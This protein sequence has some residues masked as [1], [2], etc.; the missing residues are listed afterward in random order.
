M[1]TVK[2]SPR[3]PKNNVKSNQTATIYCVIRF[4]NKKLVYPTGIKI[5]AKYWYSKGQRV[6]Q[7]KQFPQYPEIN[8]RLSKLESIVET[9]YTRF[10]NENENKSP[11]VEELR[12]SIRSVFDPDIKPETQKDFI[13]FFK[14]YL[15]NLTDVA[16]K[17]IKG[18][19]RT[20]ALL[21]GFK[22]KIPFDSI[23]YSFY[24]GFVNYMQKELKFSRNTIGKYIRIMKTVLY[25]AEEQHKK[26]YVSNKF[27]AFTEETT[28]IHLNAKELELIENLDLSDNPRLDKVRDMFIVEC[29]TGV[30]FSDL[31]QLAESDFKTDIVQITQQK[32]KTRVLIPILPPVQRILKKYNYQLPKVL[33]NQKMNLYLKEVAKLIPELKTPVQIKKSKGEMV[34]KTTKQKYEMITTH[35]ARRSFATNH[36][37]MGVPI[38]SI[39]QVTGH[40]TQQDFFKYIK[41]ES[42]TGANDFHRIYREQNSKLKAV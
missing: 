26:K 15:N 10:K 37:D 3:I 22:R 7:T 38:E 16:P 24:I 42:N 2:F 6:S 23:D 31:S 1:I 30:R 40:K 11:T 28:S 27:K 17:T 5:P 4:D 20:L 12:F 13:A 19:E 36:Y 33:T 34:V 25:E 8:S 29:W 39:M 41:R 18:R 21:T 14:E 35:T 32:T 9:C